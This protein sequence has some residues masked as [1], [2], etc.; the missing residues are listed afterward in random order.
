M[1]NNRSL[2]L[3]LDLFHCILNSPTLIRDVQS[4]RLYSDKKKNEKEISDEQPHI[5]DSILKLMT[6]VGNRIIPKNHETFN[7]MLV[8]CI[9]ILLQ[10]FTKTLNQFLILSRKYFLWT[11]L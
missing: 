2:R 5:N 7:F 3:E 8:Y 9:T 4:T 10:Q 6:T 11:M 1:K